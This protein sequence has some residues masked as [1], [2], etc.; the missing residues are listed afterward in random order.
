[1]VE[2]ITLD[3][4]IETYGLPNYIK[5]DV[6]GF[7]LPV[8]RGLSKAVALVSFECNLPMFRDETVEAIFTLGNLSAQACFN[9]MAADGHSLAS[10][11][12]LCADQMIE[13]VRSNRAGYLE[14][15]CSTRP[16]REVS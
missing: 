1:M 13:T 14:I 15:F 16:L 5:I 12:W 4:A 6:E 11:A 8:V 2:L 10:P 9:W 3:H 7:E